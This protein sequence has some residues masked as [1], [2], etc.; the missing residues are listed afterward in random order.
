MKIGWSVLCL[1]YSYGFYRTWTLPL[2]KNESSRTEQLAEIPIRFCICGLNSFHYI[3]PPFVFFKYYDLYKRIQL[4]NM[5]RQGDH[6][7]ELGF[8]HPNVF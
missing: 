4:Q 1:S 6:W 3:V 8:Y 5:A 2:W 7:R